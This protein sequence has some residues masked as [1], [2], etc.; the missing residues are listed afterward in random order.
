MIE[1][2]SRP[3]ISK[4]W[5]DEYRFGLWLK[6]ELAVCDAWAELGEIPAKSL[7]T[8]KKK[9]NF[10]TKR[11]LE[12]ESEVRHDVIAFLTSVAEFV[13]PDSRF[14]HMG[15]TS[16]D[17]LDTSFALQLVHAGRIIHKDLE[18]LLSSIEKRAQEFKRILEISGVNCTIRLRRGIDIQAGCGQ[19]AARHQST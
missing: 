18:E 8:I 16:S 3:E 2:Y 15:M 11:A 12:I 7:S 5:T 19:L 13:G 10:D 17:L 4:I 6:V 14:I 1:R 9:A